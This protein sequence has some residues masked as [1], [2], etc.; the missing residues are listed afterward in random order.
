MYIIHEQKQ[1]SYFLLTAIYLFSSLVLLLLI[2]SPPGMGLPPLPWIT[3]IILGVI[4]LVDIFIFRSFY[5]LK[6][7]ITSE[8]LEFGYGFFKSKIAKNDL[9]SIIIDT[10]KG[11]FFGYGVRFNR[12]RIM[13]YIARTGDGL[14]IETKKNKKFFV[15]INDPEQALQIIKQSKYLPLHLI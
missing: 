1:K 8:G 15:T 13:G 14:M 11:N 4:F 5:E 12:H 10:S 9:K 6:F 7:K 3:R 2:I